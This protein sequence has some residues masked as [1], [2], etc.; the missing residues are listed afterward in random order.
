M[1]PEATVSISGAPI[2]G[3]TTGPKEFGSGGTGNS[4]CYE[5]TTTRTCPECLSK[6]TLMKIILWIVGI[7]FVIGLLT[8]MGVFGLIF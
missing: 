6:E 4:N 3:R 2:P 7:I 5:T 1:P 8:V